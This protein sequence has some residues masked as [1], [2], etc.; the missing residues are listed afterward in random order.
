M[1]WFTGTVVRRHISPKIRLVSAI[2]EPTPLPR[3]RP[4]LPN[5]AA[6]TE[7]KASGIVVP[8]EIIVA[9]LAQT[10]HAML[11]LYCQDL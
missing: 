2:M 6:I 10:W 5:Q 11:R 8:S 9:P 7:T 3:A 4:G 1:N